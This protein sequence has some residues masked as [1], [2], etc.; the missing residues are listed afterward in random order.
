MTIRKKELI[1][2]NLKEQILSLKT[3][4]D[5]ILKE[6]DVARKYGVSRSPVHDALQQLKLE[7]FLEQVKKVGYVVKPLSLS[8]LKEIIQVRSVL[9]GYAASLTTINRDEKVFARLEKIN[10]KA[11]IYL[12]EN[13]LEG[14]FNNSCDF[15]DV[16]Y[17]GSKNQRVNHLIDS[18]RDDFMRYRRIWL[19]IPE[20][21]K[22][23]IK[24]HEEMLS[25]MTRG[26]E[27]LV[28]KLVREHV[29]FGGKIL[30]E[31]IEMERVEK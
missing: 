13:D 28:E 16:I 17:Q 22:V 29:I 23:Q 11:H 24:D 20:M 21:P 18:L 6:E 26:D 7:G 27:A 5:T 8:D 19:K 12:K 2:E 1:Y 25:A 15:H 10:Q 30:L 4:P 31:Y 14:F 3:R 9:E